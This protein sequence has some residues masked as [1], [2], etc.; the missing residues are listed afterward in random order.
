MTNRSKESQ[1]LDSLSLSTTLDSVL[2]PIAFGDFI[3][4]ITILE[5]KANRI[6]DRQKVVNVCSELALLRKIFD[7]FDALPDRVG[8]LKD[9][10]RGINESLWEIEDSIRDCERMKDFGGD[11]IEL[12]RS[13]YMTNDRRAA[14]KRQLNEIVGSA[15]L[16]EKSY[17][18]YL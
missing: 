5:I 17:R 14:V 7:R 13:V 18:E 9:E 6:A 16:E 4:K 12:A 15:I 1:A 2:V 3:D 8:A 11:F 10:L